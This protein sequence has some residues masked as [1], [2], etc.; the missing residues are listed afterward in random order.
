MGLDITAVSGATR[1][2]PHDWDNTDDAC[3]NMRD[4][5]DFT[6]QADGVEP[7]L[8]RCREQSS[9]CAGSYGGY[10][11]WRDDLARIAG[12]GVAHDPTGRG[13]EYFRGA[14]KAGR[15]PF[16]E[17]VNFSDCEGTIGPKTSAKL[18][19]DFKLFLA[20][21]EKEGGSFLRTYLAFL[22]AFD[23]AADG[24]FVVFH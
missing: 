3:V 10:N 2:G 13:R 1:I 7:G 23:M 21:A 24:G 11:A 5:P 17:L 6:Q 16:Q 22:L 20:A 14:L 18:A 8:Y 4:Q 19:D 15:G 9:F 12:Y